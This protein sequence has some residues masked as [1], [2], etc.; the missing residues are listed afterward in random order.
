LA[1]PYPDYKM[2]IVDCAYVIH[3]GPARQGSLRPVLDRAGIN[4]KDELKQLMRKHRLETFQI[5]E[6]ARLAN[7]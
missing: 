7:A 1:L 3:T 4:P 6:H 2:A 5:I